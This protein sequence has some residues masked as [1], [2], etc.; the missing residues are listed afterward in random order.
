MYTRNPLLQFAGVPVPG[1][2]ICTC[3]PANAA[4]EKK[5]QLLERKGEVIRLRRDCYIVNQ[6]LSGKETNVGLCA[7]HIYGPSY[8]SLQWALREYGL[9]PERVHLITSAALK[10]TRLFKTPIGNFMYLHVPYAY[11]P[12][13][14][15]SIEA[16][17][18]FYLMASPE[19]ALCDT[20]LYD[21][22]V[23]RQSVKSLRTYLE[24]DMRFDMDMLP[25][26]NPEIIDECAKTG[27]KSQIFSNLLK[28]I[29][30]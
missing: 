20:I 7:N 23:P 14:V 18:V 11:F 15:N 2:D 26:L 30:Q 29:K 12:I 16:S 27:P 9:I 10:R 25:E 22:F 6:D 24:E 21:K 17:G 28:L 5:L 8:V 4:P 19:K 3:F 13:G 1:M